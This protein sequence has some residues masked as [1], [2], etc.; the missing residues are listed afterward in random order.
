MVLI[1]RRG[2]SLR[3]CRPRI[4]LT[5][6]AR[7]A[8]PGEW[9]SKER[10]SDE[11]C[12]WHIEQRCSCRGS[13]SEEGRSTRRSMCRQ[14]PR[15]VCQHIQLCALHVVAG[16]RRA[17]ARA[18]LHQRHSRPRCVHAHPALNRGKRKK[19]GCA[20]IAD[21]LVATGNYRKRFLLTLAWTGATASML[22]IF[23][24]PG[25]YLFAPLLVI[26]AV[27]CLGNSFAL[28]NSFLPLL[29]AN[30][31]SSPATASDPAL[32]RSWLPVAPSELE[33]PVVV[34]AADHS[35]PLANAISARA[36]AAGYAAAVLVQV[37]SIGMLVL[38]AK[39]GLNGSPS[40]PMR[41]VLFLVG[42]W[43]ALFSIPTY[44]WLRPRP[45]PRLAS[46]PIT[47]RR[48]LQPAHYVAFAWRSLFRTFRSALRLRH[49]RLFLLAWF[50]VSD[51]VATISNVAILF[52]RTELHMSTPAIALVSI[53]ATVSG[54]AGAALWPKIQTRL[55]LA[56]NHTIMVCICMF[57]II[58]LYGLLGF[59]LPVLGLRQPWEIFP[60]AFVHGFAMGGI[61]SFCRAFYGVLVPP[62]S[63]VAFYAIYAVTDK[64]SSVIGPAIVGR[65]VDATGSVRMGFWFLAVLIVLP[66]PLVFWVDAES[67][68]QDALRMARAADKGDTDDGEEAVALTRGPGRS[69]DED[70]DETF[71]LAD[72]DDDLEHIPN[73]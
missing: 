56:T 59:V 29:V 41:S 31:P 53:T 68:R 55:G 9:C 40:L 58:P 64:G 60:M 4:I 70:E 69:T 35:L 21:V 2:R 49:V 51:A 17:G 27:C 63:E 30:H 36:T 23:V 39:L 5:Y 43:W 12:G 25:V 54:I 16:R 65:I 18:H 66:L 37:V 38:M 72:S 33:P 1:R 8:R 32:D 67:G 28:L 46:V 52:A 10:Q 45:G 24:S 15:R 6:H 7:A 3:R 62:G 20:G 50:L 48:W 14:C 73:R 11:L 47:T 34:L 71:G 22:F 13:G 57:E 44:L 42:A 19:E 61:S 26:L